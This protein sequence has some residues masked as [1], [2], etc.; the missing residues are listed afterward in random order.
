MVITPCDNVGVISCR[1]GGGKDQSL[2]QVPSFHANALHPAVSRHN[3][4]LLTLIQRRD[5]CILK[6]NRLIL[7]QENVF[8]V[9][10]YAQTISRLVRKTLYRVVLVSCAL[11]RGQN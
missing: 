5:V 7:I 10:K 2:I 6:R 8:K 3:L 11:L 1:W 9:Q 4:F